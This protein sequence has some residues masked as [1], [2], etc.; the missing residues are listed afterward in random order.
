M[1]RLAQ[2]RADSMK[3]IMQRKMLLANELRNT[4]ANSAT[5]RDQLKIAQAKLET[6]LS[7]PGDH[8]PVQQE[9]LQSLE[10][11]IAQVRQK[12]KETDDRIFS[13]EREVQQYQ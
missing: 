6:H 7:S 12:I 3:A 13:L 11:F 5:L 10:A 2:H 8:R 9:S 1:T 4:Q